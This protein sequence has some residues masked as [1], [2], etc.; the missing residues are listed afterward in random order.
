VT[1]IR[2][3]RAKQVILLFALTLCVVAM[4]HV[5]MSDNLMGGTSV[6]A[7]HTMSVTLAE[8]G[9]AAASGDEHPGMPSDAHGLLHLCLA[10]LSAVGAVLLALLALGSLFRPAALSATST[11]PPGSAVPERPPDRR[12]RT[13]LTSLCV[14][15]V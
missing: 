12:G 8:P 13:V 14:L 15:R 3:G 10:V 6:P 1:T 9:P 5:G 11:G 4:H 2:L 7:T